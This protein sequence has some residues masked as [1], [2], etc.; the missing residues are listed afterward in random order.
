MRIPDFVAV[1]RSR[2]RLFQWFFRHCRTGCGMMFR[3][4]LGGCN[5][6]NENDLT[7]TAL[8]FLEMAANARQN[9]VVSALADLTGGHPGLIAYASEVIRDPRMFGPDCHVLLVEVQQ[10]PEGGWDSF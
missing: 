6:N 1:F 10:G 3:R 4:H 2:S 8:Q 5:M 9:H 7:G